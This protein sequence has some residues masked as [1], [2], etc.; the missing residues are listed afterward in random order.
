MLRETYKY[1]TTNGI[2]SYIIENNKISIISY[3][4]NT[5]SLIIPYQIS[6]MPVAIIERKA[7]MGNRYLQCI[8]LPD[9]IEQIGDWAFSRCSALKKI[10]LPD[11]ELS[12]GKQVFQKS[13]NLREITFPGCSIGLAKLLAA[14]VTM[15][16]VE[17]L[18]NPEQAGNWNWYQ[19]FD[20]RMLT[21][22][23]EPEENALKNLVYCAEEDMCGKQADCIR[24]QSY[25]KARLALHRLAYDEGLREEVRSY[26]AEYV[27]QRTVGCE[28]Q[29]VWEV[30]KGELQEQKVYCE[31]LFEL[32][33]LHDH[34]FDKALEDLGE[35]HI[36]LKAFLMQKWREQK[37]ERNVWDMLSLELQL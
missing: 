30:I 19:N 27:L 11:S 29:P 23:K 31:I 8:T 12:I 18:L 21:V 6:E 16:N 35:N 37:S 25:E 26:L 15:L 28:E 13:E 36:E 33:A 1:E 17:Y 32:N 20:N 9:S 5:T 24:R 14:S 22:L 10:V 2:Y 3:E 34:N 4:G 7:F